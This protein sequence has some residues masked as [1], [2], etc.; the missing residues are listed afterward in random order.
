M[1]G[2]GEVLMRHLDKLEKWL[3]YGDI[4]GECLTTGIVTQ[5]EYY[6]FEAI[7]N[8]IKRNRDAVLKITTRPPEKIE[9]F[10]YL[11]QKTPV[12]KELGTQ[13]LKGEI[14]SIMSSLPY[15]R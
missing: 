10:C 1:E 2:F 6:D 13:M 9:E 5:Y 12:G 3:P 4:I 8:E 14:S 15:M 11:L 7:P